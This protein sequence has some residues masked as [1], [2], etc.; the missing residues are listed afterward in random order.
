MEDK[1]PVVAIFSS[2]ITTCAIMYDVSIIIKLVFFLNSLLSFQ[3][4]AQT[5]KTVLDK[6]MKLDQGTR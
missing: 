6:Y 1:T 4:H 5:N 3:M 2:Y